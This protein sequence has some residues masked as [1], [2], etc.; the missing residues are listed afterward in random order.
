MHIREHLR[1][2]A[3]ANAQPRLRLTKATHC[4]LPR[5]Q[6]SSTARAYYGS[7]RTVN[8]STEHARVAFISPTWLLSAELLLRLG[9]E[10]QLTFSRIALPSSSQRTHKPHRIRQTFFW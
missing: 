7:W 4:D 9:R 3:L 2:P 10:A 1:D 8:V 6:I 5:D